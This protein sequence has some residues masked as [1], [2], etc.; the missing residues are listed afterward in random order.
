M[1]KRKNAKSIAYFCLILILV[2]VMLFSGLQILESTVFSSDQDGDTQLESKKITRDG[3]DYFPRQD[4]TVVM[5]LGIDQY[6]PVAH[7]GSYNNTGAADMVSLLIFD[8][9]N[10]TYSVLGLNRDAMVTMPVLGIGGRL[11][12]TQ[13]AQLALSHTQGS[14]LED[15]CENVRTTVSDLL[16]DLNIDYYLS[17]NMDAIGILNDAVGGVTVNVVDDFSDMDPTITMGEVTLRGQQ[18]IN[19]VR[20]RKGV[21]DQLN[22]SRMERQKTYVNGFLTA[23]RS[24]LDRDNS[25]MLSAYEDVSEYV[26]T[27]ISTKTLSGMLQRY[28]DYEF[29]GMISLEG[30]NVLTEEFY[31]FHIDEEKMDELILKLFY[32]PK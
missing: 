1:S 8:E 11:V 5:I 9:K 13:Y 2:L 23:L 27:D 22:I 20:T 31:E 10:E 7:S 6:G 15:S 19:Y 28:A 14:G 29:T 17:M 25:F 32:A 18:A 12:G 3:V 26:V 21:G 4:I 16:Y 30:E 24:K